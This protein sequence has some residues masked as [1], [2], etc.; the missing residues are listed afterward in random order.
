MNKFSAGFTAVEL[1]IVMA[2]ALLIVGFSFKGFLLFKRNL[3]HWQERIT[4]EQAGQRIIKS[5]TE[6]LY[7]LRG[8]HQADPTTITFEDYKGDTLTYRLK[9]QNIF[10]NGYPLL[11]NQILAQFLKFEYY[12][13]EG[14]IIEKQKIE[15]IKIHLIL[16]YKKNRYFELIS[17]VKL[18]NRRSF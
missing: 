8:I 7:K 18:R 11:H 5:L 2:L 3:M 16:R 4:L 1:L 13:S 6:D 17:S 10:K 15:R 12:T 9:N 14:D